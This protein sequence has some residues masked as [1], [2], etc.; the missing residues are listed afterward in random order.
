MN[1]K[2]EKNWLEEMFNMSLYVFGIWGL[3]F[4]V[5]IFVSKDLGIHI[6]MP[7]LPRGDII[8]LSALAQLGDAFNI[9]TSLFAG[10][11]FAAVLVTIKIQ[12]EELEETREEFK[13]Q[14]EIMDL[15][16]FDNKFFQMLNVFN[17]V[18]KN[19]KSFNDG[20]KDGNSMQFQYLRKNILQEFDNVQIDAFIEK[21]EEINATY[22]L[23]LKYYFLNLYQ[24]LN[25][26][27]TDY[28]IDSF[29]EKKKYANIVR[30]QLTKDEVV[31]LLY[32][33]IGIQHISG[34][35]YKELVE[36][37]AFF[38]HISYRDLLSC[39][40]NNFYDKNRAFSELEKICNDELK[41]YDPIRGEGIQ[42]PCNYK[43]SNYLLLQYDEMAF[44][45][46][47]QIKEIIDKISDLQHEIEV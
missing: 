18:I 34:M 47:K 10:L 26:I 14:R 7:S 42:F 27:D 43:I 28:P 22:N 36:K 25:Y 6:S 4:I 29:E 11:A 30:A 20:Y 9:L 44:G 17:D 23:S 5:Y 31:L 1:K 3:F 40:S 13:K 32:N 38:E 33:C 35:R 19:I 15:Q 2:R 16:Q 21:Y 46:N 41:K 24:V 39:D 12:K 37:Y 45:S 8:K